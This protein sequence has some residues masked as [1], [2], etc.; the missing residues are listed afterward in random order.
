M[1]RQTRH[2][3][4]LLPQVLEALSRRPGQTVVDCT[5]GLGGHAAALLERVTPGGLLIGMDFDPGNIEIAR[6]RLE[7]T[8]GRFELFRNNFAALPAVLAQAGVERVDAV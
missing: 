2:I 7:A 6:P 3:P 8:G 1:K 4:V 5:L